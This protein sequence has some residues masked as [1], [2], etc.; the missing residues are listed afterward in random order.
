MNALLL[1]EFIKAILSIRKE[2]D[3]N[4]QFAENNA[5]FTCSVINTLQHVLNT[6]LN[7]CLH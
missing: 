2:I 6:V 5:F 4:L 1:T 3:P 7:D